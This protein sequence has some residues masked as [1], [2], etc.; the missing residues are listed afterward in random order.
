MNFSELY[1]NNIAEVVKAMQALWC[2][3][4]ASDSQ[5]QYSE[6]IRNLI[7]TELFAPES[8]VPVVQCMN[9]YRPVETVSPD[10]AKSLVGK[11]WT[12]EHKPYEHQYQCWNHLLKGS[13][14]GKPKSICVTTGTGS[15]K[16]EC[17]MMPL[18]HN[19][20]EINKGKSESEMM[21]IQALFLYPL[22][23]LM[24][25]QKGRLEE[26]LQ[27]AEATTGVRLTYAVYN[28][29]LPEEGPKASDRP[30]VRERKEKVIDHLRGAYW[31]INPETGERV[32][33]YKY[34]HML[35]TRKQVRETP[36]NILLTN[37]TMLEYILL[38][39]KDEK[40]IEPEKKTLKWVAI[41]ETH[42]YTGAG[43]AE[44]AMLLRRVLLA[45]DVSANDVR[46]AT[47]SATFGN[48]ADPEEA[49]RQ[50]K[51]F[52][53]GI[54]G[55][56]VDQIEPVSGERLGEKEIIDN[57][58][59][60]GERW[61]QLFHADFIE[62]D[63]LF[64]EGK[65][66]EQKLKMFDEMCGRVA[67][68]VMKAKV[69]YF[70][71]VPNNGL[72]VRLNDKE[73]KGA[74][75]IHTSN[76]AASKTLEE[77][78]P[79]TPMLELT[80]CKN[81]GEFLTVALLDTKT[82]KYS[83]VVSD[84]SD[85]FDIGDNNDDEP[86][87]YTVLG[88]SNKTTY[89]GDGNKR[90][91]AT[92]KGEILA[93]TDGETTPD[94]WFLLGNQRRCCPCC[95]KKLIQKNAIEQ[96]N[97]ETKS[98]GAIDDSYLQKFRV[99][100]E[101]ISRVL[102]PSILDQLDK[103]PNAANDDTILHDGQ[104]YISFA[105]S[106]QM[107]ANATL[108]QNM[109]QERM[110]FYTTVYHEL[111]KRKA[112][113]DLIEQQIAELKNQRD[114]TQDEDEEEEL[115][116]KIKALRKKKKLHITWD[117]LAKV[118]ADDKYSKVFCTQFVKRSSDSEEMDDDDE[119]KPAVLDNYIHSIMVMYLSSRP[120]K[121]AAPETLGLFHPCYPQLEK[122]K[123]IPEA[124]KSFNQLLSNEDN[125]IKIKDWRN[126]IQMYIDYRI[127]S[128][129]SLFLM[130]HS[131]AKVDIFST[132]RFATE[133]AHRKPANKPELDPTQ[134]SASRIVRYL[135]AL[136]S[137]ENG[138]S[139]FDNYR[140]SF[141]QIKAVI[142]ALWE[143]LIASDAKL[144]EEGLRILDEKTKEFEKDDSGLRFNLAN[145]SFKL[146]DDVYLC[147]V[148]KNKR[149][150]VP[151]LRP[152]ETNFKGFSPYLDGNEPV[153]LIDDKKHHEIWTSYK[154]Y[155]GSGEKPTQDNIHAWAKENRSILWENNLWGTGG[156][157]ADRLDD[158]H[159]VP[160]YFIQAEHTAQVDK[161]VSRGL[162]DDFK[163][164]RINILACS[165][166][167]ELG[168]DLGNLEVV[169]LSSV[170]PMPANYKQ[171]AGR[172]GRN[173][174]IKSVCITLCG[175]DAIGLR[176]LEHPIETIIKREVCVPK[177]DLE[178]KQVVQ[179]HVNSFL[180]R[181][182]GV[183]GNGGGSVNQK[184]VDYYSKFEVAFN[185]DT[186]RFE[187]IYGNE[188]MSPKA[189]LGKPDG[190]MYKKFE[191]NCDM[192][193]IDAQ[194]QAHLVTLLKDTVF[195]GD[196]AGVV[197]SA[198]QANKDRYDELCIKLEDYAIALHNGGKP[199]SDK[200][201]GLLNMKYKEVLTERLLTYWSTNRFTPNANM[202][203]N[204]LSLDLTPIGKNRY[205][206][207]PTSS[208][209]SY[210]LREAIAQYTPGN[211]IVVDGVVYQ[212]SG[213]QFDNMFQSGKTFQPIARNEER[214][215]YENVDSIAN[216]IPWEVN[217]QE[218]VELVRPVG[219][220]PDIKDSKSRITDNKVF[221]HVNAQLIDA[222]EW[223]DISTDEYLFKLRSNKDVGT[224]RILY[225]NEGKGHGY[226]LCTACGRAVLESDIAE[227]AF[228][229]LPK[230]YNPIPPKKKV[231]DNGNKKRNFH[232]AL[233]GKQ[234]GSVCIGSNFEE[235]IKR[236]III[237]D[238]L[239][240]DFCEIK[241]RKPNEK[242]LTNRNMD[243]ELLYTLGIVLTQSLAEYL[244]KERNAIDFT[245]MP[246]AHLCVFDTN[247]G[248]AGYSNQ[249]AKLDDASQK[250]E[251]MI[252]VLEEARILLNKAKKKNARDILL[253]K[254][255]LRYMKYINIEKTLDWIASTLPSR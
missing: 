226:C 250:P 24:E 60:D 131:G 245:I 105:D 42:T 222:D 106:R 196:V 153:E 31:E 27:Q 155:V 156:V 234:A 133:K 229:K 212:V 89:L 58:Y 125:K 97:E 190:T 158:I 121:D 9:L 37:P 218:C 57:E 238:L 83:A 194:T 67:G 202:P 168:V 129:Q 3:E 148:N 16:T 220:L 140:Q 12:S 182:F 116:D 102:A 80:R 51:Q 82:D 122:I 5:K 110:W 40:L 209:P 149:I 132:V 175:S 85:M 170:P 118:L 18:V 236:N 93:M 201:R 206:T 197:A 111:C 54:T 49:K 113:T 246:N 252:K 64:P 69:H 127:R 235:K 63:K 217:G 48:G 77:V 76:D 210:P 115:D 75:R 253:D 247:P 185:K 23:A 163:Q 120:L 126:L 25:D 72:F 231:D 215:V 139:L 141:D 147:D 165:T 207:S 119:I 173:N 20:T 146:Y 180:V 128:D 249:L 96:E 145:M 171:R 98:A 248:G 177:V 109:E 224:A 178:S 99:S 130:P 187:V 161:V 144:L 254:F 30:K 214:T 34:E 219:F 62:L 242:W 199:I 181:A 107:A 38:R 151:C 92:I 134:L 88:L 152:I 114:N 33:K 59:G 135:C 203:V 117:D 73:S 244:G 17:F 78:A 166:T 11:L 65:N 160:N 8:A 251:M 43:A 189:K 137:K 240:T 138:L 14:N 53:A 232:W 28:G 255:T 204:V 90:Y 86:K 50:L 225:Y 10:D 68:G 142:D 179:R 195:D 46:W 87:K 136:I 233:T 193:K 52:I 183:F 101:F 172:S 143:Q 124:V 200:Y 241:I 228:D 150:D 198:K 71:R 74:F 45:F 95:G 169:M 221:T 237:G 223:T 94:G 208:N 123:D 1:S 191:E 205:D 29:D 21:Q 81:C 154:M 167:M 32:K 227:N 61:R 243:L 84:D 66:I 164:H 184:V 7:R 157:F 13:V 79:Q 22:N 100:A 213:V 44:L 26:L 108:K 186:N 41:D 15:G 216:K 4:S 103:D 211:S 159:A 55:T 174:K 239:Q 104:Q 39:K 35:Y 91:R 192:S 19:L 176:T 188:V 56:H 6:Q 230:D 47:S 70:Y 112:E 36:P 162:Q 2:G